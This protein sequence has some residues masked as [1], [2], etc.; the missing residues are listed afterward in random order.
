MITRTRRASAAALL[1]AASLVSAPGA[2]A[3][4]PEVAGPAVVAPVTAPD[5]G[6]ASPTGMGD[7]TKRMLCERWGLFCG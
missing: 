7:S 2:A 6:E 5:Q 4:T 3:S 1:A